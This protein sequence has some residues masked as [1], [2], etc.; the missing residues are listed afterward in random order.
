ME[1]FVLQFS[2]NPTKWSE[3]WKIVKFKSGTDSDDCSESDLLLLLYYLILIVFDLHS[4]HFSSLFAPTG[5][6]VNVLTDF[7][8]YKLPAFDLIIG[9]S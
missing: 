8:I 4:E 6:N 2:T 7:N 5:Y 3:K 1:S 9:I